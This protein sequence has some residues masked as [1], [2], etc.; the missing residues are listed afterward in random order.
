[1]FHSTIVEIFH[2]KHLFCCCVHGCLDNL[3]NSRN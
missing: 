3:S 2:G 1:V